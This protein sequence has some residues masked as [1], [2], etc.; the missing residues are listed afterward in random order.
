MKRL[1]DKFKVGVKS[2]KCDICLKEFT[3][4]GNV[5]LHRV[6]VH[7]EHKFKCDLCDY[8]GTAQGS[9]TIHQ[10]SKHDGLKFKCLICFS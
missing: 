1:Y 10:Q 8:T 9:L 7:L 2:T 3:N 6:S 5:V 4:K